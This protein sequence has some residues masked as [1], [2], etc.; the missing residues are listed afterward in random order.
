VVTWTDLDL[1]DNGTGKTKTAKI[2]AELKFSKRDQDNIPR[3]L[4]YLRGNHF[5]I[6]ELKFQSN[7]ASNNTQQNGTQENQSSL[8][9]LRTLI[10]EQL[11]TQLALCPESVI[12][13]DEFELFHRRTVT[14][15]QEFLDATYPVIT[16]NS[17]SWQIQGGLTPW[18]N[19]Q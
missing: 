3:G 10:R 18:T 16:Y 1:Q 15:F 4:L 13:I 14:V 17:K 2:L 11:L 7:D 6:G 8:S 12:I 19:D 5:R 9:R